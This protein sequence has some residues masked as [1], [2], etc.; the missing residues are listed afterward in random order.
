MLG[1]CSKAPCPA[2]LTLRA[3]AMISTSTK[4][5]G[6]FAPLLPPRMPSALEGCENLQNRFSGCTGVAVEENVSSPR[7][8]P[9]PG[10][11]FTLNT[12][13]ILL[14]LTLVGR[15]WSASEKQCRSDTLRVYT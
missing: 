13:L 12:T 15:P 6:I 2:I 7:K 3:S 11:M 8:N 1:M 5:K 4:H 9:C 10:G 14:H